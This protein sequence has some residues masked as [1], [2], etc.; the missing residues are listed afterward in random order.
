MLCEQSVTTNA[1][2]PV[3]ET[4]RPLKRHADG[5]AGENAE[6]DIRARV[7]DLRA[8]H[9]AHADNCAHGQVDAAEQDA[10]RH[11]EG[12]DGVDGDL[13]QNVQ[14]VAQRQEFIADERHADDHNQQEHI[15]AEIFRQI[16]AQAVGLLQR[17]CLF[18][19]DFPPNAYSMM[20]FCVIS[21]GSSMILTILPFAITQTRWQ[22]LIISGSSEETQITLMPSAA[23]SEMMR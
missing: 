17:F 8:Q 20:R 2:M 19:H 18:V 3:R 4:S 23:R 16:A 22:R 12:D 7:D 14:N 10:V 6:V 9:A 21:A 11:A 1:G 15:N 13:T 5:D